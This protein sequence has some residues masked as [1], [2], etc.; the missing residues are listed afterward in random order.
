VTA[1]P[2]GAKGAVASYEEAVASLATQMAMKMMETIDRQAAEIIRQS[3]IISSMKREG[4]T[5]AKP[6][7]ELRPVTDSLPDVVQD[8]IKARAPEGS[9]G[10]KRDLQRFASAQLR[11]DA[12]PNKVAKRIL[13]GAQEEEE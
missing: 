11:A 12:D 5:P 2:N 6:V 1:K 8:A 10:L 13:D 7:E 9:G 3:E 4:F